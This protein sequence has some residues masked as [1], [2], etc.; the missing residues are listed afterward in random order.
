MHIIFKKPVNY[1]KEDLESESPYLGIVYTRVDGN[2]NMVF[3]VLDKQI[4]LLAVLKYGI[5]FEEIN[6]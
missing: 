3:K 5:V 4:F 2:A 6:C 1:T